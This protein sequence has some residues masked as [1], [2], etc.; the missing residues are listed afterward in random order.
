MLAI[1]RF[2]FPLQIMTDLDMRKKLLRPKPIIQKS[3]HLMV[4]ITCIPWLS[5]SE[6]KKKNQGKKN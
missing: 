6:R 2:H 4:T 1:F 3:M 5:P